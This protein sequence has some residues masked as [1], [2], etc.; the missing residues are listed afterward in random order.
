MWWWSIR[1]VHLRR[2]QT[3][4]GERM[5]HE[6]HTTAQARVTRSGTHRSRPTQQ[7][8]EVECR[9]AGHRRCVRYGVLLTANAFLTAQSAGSEARKARSD[10]TGPEVHKRGCDVSIYSMAAR[11][12]PPKGLVTNDEERVSLVALEASNASSRKGDSVICSAWHAGLAAG[13]AD[14]LQLHSCGVRCGFKCSTISVPVP[15]CL[16]EVAAFVFGR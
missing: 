4:V 9:V 12:W 8:V 13:V 14:W 15:S 7:S 6:S 11:Q 1:L 16:L 10:E 3:A 5:V 2:F